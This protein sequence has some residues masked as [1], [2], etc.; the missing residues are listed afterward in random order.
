M[1]ISKRP[2][3]AMSVLAA[4][5]LLIVATSAQAT[6]ATVASLIDGDQRIFA[7]T[8]VTAGANSAI[9]GNVLAGTYLTTGVKTEINGSTAAGTA[10]TLGANSTVTGSVQSGTTTTVGANASG[11]FKD[12]VPSDTTQDVADGQKAILS[13]H[14]F[15]G[16]FGAGGYFPP[17]NIAEDTT[18]PRV[19][20]EM[21]RNNNDRPTYIFGISGLLTV[22]ANK[23]IT[24]D[25]KCQSTTFLFNVSSYLTFGENATVEVINHKETDILC[26]ADVDV[27]VIWNV[28]G[29][30]VSLGARANIVGTVL[31][32]GYVSTGA[33][34]TLRCADGV[35]SATSYVSIGAHGT[36]TDGATVEDGGCSVEAT[37]LP[38]PVTAIPRS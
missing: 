26:D 29:G 23:T 18:L 33:N 11:K 4:G 15:M 17:G 19:G 3:A 24:L 10:T 1:K 35:Y 13:A 8:Y 5:A 32:H 25:A 9:D 7:G 21:D 27:D 28:S 37:V 12:R 31:A 16:L 30:Y 20:D 2:L 14:G 22:A 6:T 38:T 34:S 36:V